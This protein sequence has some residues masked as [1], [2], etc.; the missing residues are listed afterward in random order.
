MTSFSM[1]D[2]ISRNLEALCGLIVRQLHKYSLDTA[3]HH[4]CDNTE[5]AHYLP[6]FIPVA[7]FTNMD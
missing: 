2:D 7:A 6:S 4:A 1:T 3:Q 5:K